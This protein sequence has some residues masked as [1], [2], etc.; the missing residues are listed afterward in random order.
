MNNSTDSML[1][2]LEIK[3]HDA[4]NNE[5]DYDDDDAAAYFTLFESTLLII[6]QLCARVFSE[7]AS[8][9]AY[10]TFVTVDFQTTKFNFHTHI[11]GVII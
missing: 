2:W 11:V 8:S 9:C 10:M 5:V 3:T 7:P 6:K 1:D 4:T